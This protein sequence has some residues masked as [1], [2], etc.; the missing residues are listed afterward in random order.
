M[1]KNRDDHLSANCLTGLLEREHKALFIPVLQFLVCN[2]L[3]EP[4]SNVVISWDI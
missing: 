2:G 4:W 1:G 3:W